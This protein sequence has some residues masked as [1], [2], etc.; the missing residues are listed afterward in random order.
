MRNNQ[1]NKQTFLKLLTNMDSK[2]K[3]IDMFS[4]YSNLLPYYTEKDNT[5]KSKQAAIMAARIVRDES[6]LH[7]KT[8]YEHG[9]T[10]Y[11]NEVILYIELL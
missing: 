4:K 10:A 8:T 7:D 5:I 6:L 2:E 9:R 1:N 3:A 11:W